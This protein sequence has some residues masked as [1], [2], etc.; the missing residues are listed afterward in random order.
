MK[1]EL[2]KLFR[3]CLVDFVI[4]LKKD[5]SLK[6]TDIPH[7]YRQTLHPLIS[8]A[9]FLQGFYLCPNH[10]QYKAMEFIQMKYETKKGTQI[11]L[12]ADKQWLK[13]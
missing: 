1:K 3:I 11:E 12:E 6:K 4:S 5:C 13:Y 10:S 9:V 8:L 2:T 7:F